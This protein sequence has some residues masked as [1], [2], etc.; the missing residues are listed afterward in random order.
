MIYTKMVSKI[1]N[2]DNI[3]KMGTSTQIR[4]QKVE[5]SQLS[6]EL[7]ELALRAGEAGFHKEAIKLYDV[8]GDLS[9]I[10]VK[11]QEQLTDNI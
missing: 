6:S 3:K 11:C 10:A 2:N 1:V 9:Y 5:A 4:S 7:Q 8:V